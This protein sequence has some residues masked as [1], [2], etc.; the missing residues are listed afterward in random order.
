MGMLHALVDE[1]GGV[2]PEGGEFDVADVADV[3]DVGDAA[4]HDLPVPSLCLV[5]VDQTSLR[6]MMTVSVYRGNGE[7]AHPGGSSMVKCVFACLRVGAYNIRV[8]DRGYC[9]ET[10]RP[11]DWPWRHMTE[12]AKTRGTCC[13]WIT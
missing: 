9:C 8:G 3:A 11:E 12:R 1:H 6:P 7:R 5:C 2:V 10:S 4:K 13:R